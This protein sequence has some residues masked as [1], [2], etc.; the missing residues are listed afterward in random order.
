MQPQHTSMC[1]IAGHYR[2]HL[3]TSLPDFSES[4]LA[5]LADRGPEGNGILQNERTHFFHSRLGIIAPGPEGKQPFTDA[6]GRYWLVLNGEILNFVE[7]RNQLQQAGLKFQ[8]QTDT[9]IVLH[10][11]IQEGRDFLQKIR[12]FFA[13]AWYD[14]ASENLLLARDH[15]GIKP[16]MW[17]QDANGI[18]FASHSQAILKMGFPARVDEV[19]LAAYLEFHFI[20]PE[21][22]MWENLQPLPAGHALNIKA[23]SIEL[24]SWV[25]PTESHLIKNNSRQLVEFETLFQQ[26]IQRNLVADVPAGIFLSGG[27]DSSLLAAGVHHY[28]TLPL[29]AF[30][31]SFKNALLDESFSAQTRAKA[32]GWKWIPVA[33]E[34]NTASKWLNRMTEPVGDPAGIGIYRL[35]EVAAQEVKM[36]IS[37]DGADELF[38]GY[39]R[40]KA[41]QLFRNLSIPTFPVPNWGGRESS[42]GNY[43]RKG[44]RLLQFLQT[45][46]KNRYRMLCG[47]RGNDSAKQLMLSDAVYNFPASFPIPDSFNMGSILQADRRF[48]LPGNMLPKSDLTGMACGLEIRVPYL[49]E[50]LVVWVNGHPEILGQGKK[51]LYQTWKNL[52]GNPFRQSKKGLDIPL[53]TIFTGSILE[54]WKTY[55]EA[56]FLKNQGIFASESFPKLGSSQMNLEQAW[57]FIVW[58]EMWMRAQ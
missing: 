34:N 15:L 6:S 57:A 36:V 39:A 41:W 16:L 38:G 14:S 48:I 20:P 56:D 1:G 5:S 11:L 49:D 52:Q 32:F 37:G 45:P 18:Y 7:L 22:S 50:D 26:S 58:Q 31:L 8:T 21:R 23:Q 47:F 40:Y 46:H 25:A 13:L 27:I 43:I 51:L 54:R 29:T 28:S 35:S 33:L 19:S 10:G 4:V 2:K 55:T 17:A 44:L 9:E 24:K 3:D 53:S 30:S 12:G 42:A